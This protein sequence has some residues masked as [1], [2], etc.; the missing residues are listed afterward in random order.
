MLDKRVPYGA[1][2][3]GGSADATAVVQ[4]VDALFGL[5]LAEAELIDCAAALGSDTA[6]FVRNAPQLW[7]GP[8]RGDAAREAGFR[9]I[10]A[11]DREAR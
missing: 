9:R 5:Q 8:R 1:G 2:L 3:G 6:F 11:A 4:G 7:H 10:Y